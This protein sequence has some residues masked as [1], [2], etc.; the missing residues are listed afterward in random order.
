MSPGAPV[1]IQWAL[2]ALVPPRK[3]ERF[4]VTPPSHAETSSPVASAA[5]DR[6][7]QVSAPVKKAPA[8]RAAKKAPLKAVD[9]VSRAGAKAP[10]A[11][12]A[13]T[14][15]DPDDAGTE[16]GD[17]PQDGELE[18]V[19]PE[20]LIVVNDEGEVAVPADVVVDI[21]RDE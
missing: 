10:A 2:P 8:K 13:T 16:L 5:P 18:D 19:S 1:D 9:P 3:P 20:D 14:A 15:A 17:V 21:E 6:A 12:A 7:A 11:R 4:F